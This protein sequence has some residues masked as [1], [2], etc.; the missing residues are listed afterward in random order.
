MSGVNNFAGEGQGKIHHGVVA[1]EKSSAIAEEKLVPSEKVTPS[2]EVEKGTNILNDMEEPVA[3]IRR[4]DLDNF[5]GK[6]TVSTGW[7][8]LDHEWLKRKF[9]IIEPDFYFKN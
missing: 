8:N 4:K 1:E 7:F 5:Q 2:E 6:S 3:T 9:C